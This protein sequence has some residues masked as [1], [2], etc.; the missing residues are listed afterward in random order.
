LNGAGSL[1]NIVWNGFFSAKT[2][3]S[4]APVLRALIEQMI[5]QLEMAAMPPGA[6]NSDDGGRRDA[7]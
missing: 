4:D 7:G 5:P 6:S 2:V 1:E 3:A